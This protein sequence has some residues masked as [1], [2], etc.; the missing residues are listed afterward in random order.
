M[1][2]I[3]LLNCTPSHAW[4]RLTEYISCKAQNPTDSAIVTLSLTHYGRFKHILEPFHHVSE[5]KT[6]RKGPL[7]Y[8][9]LHDKPHTHHK[10]AVI[11]TLSHNLELKWIIKVK[12]GSVH[13]LAVVDTASTVTHV[14]KELLKSPSLYYTP[15]A[16]LPAVTAANGSAIPIQGTVKGN[17]SI[18]NTGFK[19]PETFNVISIPYRGIGM[20]LGQDFQSKYKIDILNSTNSLTWLYRGHMYGLKHDQCV[21]PGEVPPHKTEAT[22]PYTNPKALQRD[23]NKGGR[24]ILAVP[25]TADPTPVCAATPMSNTPPSTSTDTPTVGPSAE[26]TG[27][28]SDKQ[29]MDEDITDEEFDNIVKQL[30]KPIQAVIK[31]HRA[32]FKNKLP[33][34]THNKCSKWRDSGRL[35]I[36]LMTEEPVHVKRRRLSPKE[37]AE[38]EAQIKEFTSRGVLRYSQSPYNAPL[39]FVSKADGSIRMCVDYTMLNRVTVKHRGP[40]PNIQD[41]LDLLQGKMFFSSIDLVNGY[42]QILLSDADIPKTAFS[43]PWGH[44]E[45]VVIWEGLTNAPAVFQSVMNDVFRPHLGKSILIYLDDILVFSRTLEEHAHHI[46]EVLTLMQQNNL[47]AKLKKCDF[48]KPELKY[49]GHIISKD[50]IKVDPA[51]I[52]KVLEWPTPKSTK[53]LLSFL[54]LTG[55][56]QKFI[57]DYSSIIAP[58]DHL[59]TWAHT[60]TEFSPWGEEQ[61]QAF[62]KLKV[63]MSSA[64]V[65]QLPDPTKPYTVFC[66]ASLYGIGAILMQDDHPVAYLSKKFTKEQINYSTYEQEFTAVVIALDTWRCYLEGNHFT[67]CT[68][69]EPLTYYN[70]QP[71]LNRRQARWLN[72]MSGFDFTWK[73]IKGTTNPSDPLSRY[74][75]FEKDPVINAAIYQRVK[76]LMTFTHTLAPTTRSGAIFSPN[77][78][79]WIQEH[80]PDLQQDATLEKAKQPVKEGSTSTS[81]QQYLDDTDTTGD[82]LL[83]SWVTQLLKAYAKDKWFRNS[84]NVANLTLAPNGLWFRENNQGKPQ[85]VVPNDLQLRSLL[86]H[87]FHDAAYAGHPGINT[88]YKTI[89][90]HYWWPGMSEAVKAHVQHCTKCQQNKTLPYTQGQLQPLQLPT[91]R[92][93][94][95]SLDLVTG[96]PRTTSGHD[97]VLTVVDRFSKMVHFIPTTKTCTAPQV[98]QMLLDNIVRLHGLPQSVVSDRDPRFATSNFIKSLWDLTGTKLKTSTAY[99]PQTDGLTERYN[100]TLEQTLTQDVCSAQW[101]EL[102]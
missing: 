1:H 95:I 41:L 9:V 38:L 88:M 78:Q 21:P 44:Y 54:G 46:D 56:F 26:T 84:K 75:G 15:T 16:N 30:P 52:S 37:H 10:T 42:R 93:E 34:G 71:Q 70:S 47:F 3:N 80:Q 59:R 89:S 53:E 55:Y 61:Q 27:P 67:L 31:K 81:G 60:W 29:L 8:L 40:L 91:Q 12:I 2:I 79:N 85:I 32:V 64:P 102:G 5:H 14:D 22:A 74:P 6:L 86:L 20:I 63:A 76:V 66:D 49:L 13:T 100:R 68:D 23:L 99:H 57:Q 77:L 35:V 24:L 36:P 73:H 4:N 50:G 62:E 65:L 19:V 69:H 97:A 94:S 18:T 72:R 17:F 98:A 7:P 11:Q 51:K 82:P 58:L 45:A 48:C 101:Q 87:E 33:A 90:Q 96:L 43:T 25:H 39:V 83:D 92:W 28:P